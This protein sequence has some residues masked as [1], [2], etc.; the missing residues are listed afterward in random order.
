MEL[1]ERGSQPVDSCARPLLQAAYLF[2]NS[3]SK[4]KVD[5]RLKTAVLS[6]AEE[7]C[8]GIRWIKWHWQRSS[9]FNFPPALPLFAAVVLWIGVDAFSRGAACGCQA[10]WIL[11]L[12]PRDM[13]YGGGM[14]VDGNVDASRSNM[15]FSNCGSTGS[16]GGD[17]NVSKCV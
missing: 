11:R 10:H 14:Y 4:S 12:R 17:Q 7:W 6:V 9:L 1:Q 13:A 16:G 2:R 15:S 8:W 3:F 5:W